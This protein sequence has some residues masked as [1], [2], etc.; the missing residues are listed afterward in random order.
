MITIQNGVFRYGS[1]D[2][3]IDVDYKEVYDIDDY[4]DNLLTEN[5]W[6]LAIPNDISEMT[7]FNAHN[8]G[9]FH[10]TDELDYSNE[11][12]EWFWD[13]E[14]TYL[15]AS[16]EQAVNFMAEYDGNFASNVQ[17][18]YEHILEQ[19]DIEKIVSNYRCLCDL[20]KKVDEDLYLE[21]SDFVEVQNLPVNSVMAT[22][23]SYILNAYRDES[24][25]NRL[26]LLN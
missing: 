7:F 5:C 3:I 2:G 4:F 1:L 11:Y 12:F 20:D 25:E 15:F 21:L 24:E 17:D 10:I 9:V 6:V 23:K 18:F 22:L 26:S 14:S 13:T 16:K 8:N 19:I